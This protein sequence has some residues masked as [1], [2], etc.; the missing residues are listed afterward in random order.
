MSSINNNDFVSY[1]NTIYD[2]KSYLDKYGGSFMMFF[3][4]I[5]VFT[6]C[7]TYLKTI[8]NLK[9]L[10]QNWNK[11]R[12]NPAYIPFA[13]VINP[14][15]GK[16][17]SQVVAENLSDCTTN[18]L[19]EII[20]FF[21]KP[22]YLIINVL[23]TLFKNITL[24]IQKMRVFMKLLRNKLGDMFKYVYGVLANI[25]IFFQVFLI[26][27]KDLISKIANIIV[28]KMGILFTKIKMVET[29][30][31][32]I[33]E[34]IMMS[35]IF[36]AGYVVAFFFS[37]YLS[38]AAGWAAL[39]SGFLSWGAIFW[40]AAAAVSLAGGIAA[41]IFWVATEKLGMDISE[42][43]DTEFSI[44]NRSFPAPPN[45]ER[46]AGLTKKDRDKGNE[47]NKKSQN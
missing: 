43:T 2:K 8:S 14:Q 42:M 46:D 16:K 35:L 24:S 1:I 37:A 31:S 23:L 39:G 10:R 32:K 26:K 11:H 12:C 41:T 22:I 21:V 17:N 5:F 7:Y 27:S 6:L 20:G 9:P 30:F 15:P 4:I 34:F 18:I 36:L 19:Q 3:L 44:K 38:F 33:H 45:G 29:L 40:F 25:M 47:I 13:G 28:I